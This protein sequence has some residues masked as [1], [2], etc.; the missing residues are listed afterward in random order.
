MKKIGL[1]MLTL[2]VALGALGIGYAA[3]TDDINVTGTV[4]TG[5]LC[6]DIQSGTIEEVGGC[7]D[8]N[9]S[10]WVTTTSAH[11]RSCPPGYKFVS[12]YNAPE[13]K[14]VADVTFNP[15]DTDANGFYDKLEVTINNAYPHFA[16]DIS[17]WICNCGTIPLIVQA[18]VIEQSPFLLIQYGD[19]IGAQ[20]HPEDC[21]E[22]SFY[23]GVVQHEGY[24]NQA[25][26][27]IVDDPNAALLPQNATLT[28]T[29]DITGIQWNEYSAN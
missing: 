10:G 1:L 29:I 11:T 21:V 28:F 17:F 20:L 24:F 8:K 13:G 6:L 22:I 23:V 19:N 16:A 4:E 3:W 14:C 2:V 15:I 26:Q 18:P 12:I 5:K 27:W 7:P 9:W 25:H